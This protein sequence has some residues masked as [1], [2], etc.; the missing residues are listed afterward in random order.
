LEPTASQKSQMSGFGLQKS[1]S[2]IPGERS[3]L[4][5]LGSSYEKKQIKEQEY[6]YE[7]IAMLIPI[8]TRLG[9]SPS[10]KYWSSVK[11]KA[12]FSLDWVFLHLFLLR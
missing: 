6:Y 12:L 2:G 1:Q 5:L 11:R 8:G 10:R 7:T 4:W 3:C 9:Q